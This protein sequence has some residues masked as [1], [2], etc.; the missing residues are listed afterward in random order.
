MQIVEPH[1]GG[2]ELAVEPRIV[3][4]E[5]GRR[6]VG[7]QLAEGMIYGAAPPIVLGKTEA[8]AQEQVLQRQPPVGHRR[9]LQPGEQVVSVVRD[10][11]HRLQQVMLF[12]RFPRYL[13]ESGPSELG[14][15][16]V[17]GEPWRRIELAVVARHL[18]FGQL[19]ADRA[20]NRLPWVAAFVG[21]EQSVEERGDVGRWAERQDRL[22]SAQ[23]F[24]SISRLSMA[25]TKEWLFWRTTVRTLS[26]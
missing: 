21:I 1:Q 12:A 16:F 15:L 22:G 8:I 18:H 2:H 6:Q 23:V 11:G 10:Q 17:G 19:D 25:S 14:H 5:G 20:A 13:H 24:S 4:G 26:T 7:A 9:A 3:Q